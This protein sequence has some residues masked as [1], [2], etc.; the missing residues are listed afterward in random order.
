M[1]KKVDINKYSSSAK[2]KKKKIL[3]IF[4]KILL[5]FGKT[6]LT[7]ILL[8]FFS[9]IFILIYI[10]HYITSSSDD[11]FLLD[12]NNS[13]LSLTSF[14]YV[15]NQ[16]YQ[17]IYSVE[18]RIWV[19][20][21][22][23]PK[24]MKDAIISIEDKR[25]YNHAGVDFFRTTGAVLSLMTGKPLYGGSTLTQQ[26]V[27]NVTG[28]SKL[29]LTRK[30]RE[31]FRALKLEETHSKDEILELYL[32]I[33][34]FGAGSRG[35]ETAANIYFDKNIKNCSLLECATIASITQNPT[36][37][38]PLNHPEKNKKRRELILS[39]ML[40]Q[41]KITKQEYIQA[42]GESENIKL[43]S[44]NNNFKDNNLSNEVRNWYI[45]TMLKD[46]VK[47]LCEKY[48]IGKESAENILY[49][50]GLKIYC[51]MDKNAQNI[52]EKNVKNS[53]LDPKL[54]LGYILMDFNGRIL[55]ILGSRK[56]KTGNLLYDRANQ[57]RRQPGSTIKPLSAYTLALDIGLY[58]YSSIISDKPL[59]LET[60][61]VT[62]EWP[63]NWYSGYRGNVI[64]QWALEKSA[65]APVA[66]I[67]NKLG[68]KRSYDFLTNK[69]KFYSLDRNDS[70]SL[71]A[72]ATGG[73]HVGV[74]VREMTAAFQIFGNSGRYY[75][76]YT[77]DYI[78]DRNNKI[79]LDNRTNI[80]EQVINPQTATVMNKLLKNV[81]TGPEGTG[82]LA[83]INDWNIIGKTGTTTDDFDSWFLGMSPYAVS[84][85]WVGY[86]EPRRIKE[87]SAAIKIWKS[88]MEEYLKNKSKIDYN[89]DNKVKENLYCRS[90]GLLAN[91]SC[92]SKATGYYSNS[93]VPHEC[94]LH[95]YT[96]F[97][98]GVI[99]ENIIEDNKI[100]NDSIENNAQIDD[101]DTDE[102]LRETSD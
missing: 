7:I 5:T 101:I 99:K 2:Y 88:I 23:I 22:E 64:L 71:S 54:E 84:G 82:K 97:T 67:I 47:D 94:N 95:G 43:S 31:S 55:A 51:S 73:T 8:C 30:L 60:D 92:P 19:D 59:I 11:S 79:I 87:I 93:N 91:P 20:F 78:T 27:K 80:P 33:V 48:N 77:Y 9:G 16:E 44:K 10:K 24:Y 58:N 45:E 1:K 83:N 86:D 35:A 34:N 76:P 90:T 36:A 46:I 3:N 6:F 102:T 39:E 65:N 61:G 96:R 4:V 89:Y 12:I 38:N 18:N 41:E 70:T 32:N 40:I 81:V 53:L 69:L 66:Q 21:K 74:T 85:I 14:I 98:N 72:L 29:S 62:R 68:T 100:E 49:R 75:K 25:F 26:C 56:E 37:Y 42:I 57:A 50:Q 63:L 52:V 17:K 13:K 15:D 28:D